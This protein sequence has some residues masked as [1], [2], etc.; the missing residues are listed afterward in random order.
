MSSRERAEK[1]DELR[2]ELLREHGVK[3]AGGAPK[4][5]GRI[6]ALRKTIAR[7]LTIAGA[8]PGEAAKPAPAPPPRPA[9]R[10]PKTPRGAAKASPPGARKAKAA[11]KAAPR[12]PRRKT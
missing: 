5:P 6:R 1:L 2:A 12:A 4:N 9:A 11:E 8:E 7:I 10:A 3:A